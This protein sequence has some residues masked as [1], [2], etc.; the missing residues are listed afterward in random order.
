VIGT[1]VKQCQKYQLIGQFEFSFS[2]LEGS[3]AQRLGAFHINIFYA[4]LNVV[5]N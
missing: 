4:I 3:L 2:V 5:Q 1:I